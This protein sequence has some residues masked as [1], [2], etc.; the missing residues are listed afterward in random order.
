[1]VRQPLNMITRGFILAAEWLI[2]TSVAAAFDYSYEPSSFETYRIIGELTHRL[3]AS[4]L[5]TVAHEPTIAERIAVPLWLRLP[6]SDWA[7]KLD[8]AVA[9]RMESIR[10]E[11]NYSAWSK[12]PDDIVF[13]NDER[14]RRLGHTWQTTL[15]QVS[16]GLLADNLASDAEN[17][18]APRKIQGISS[19][20]DY[21]LASQDEWLS[22]SALWTDVDFS[23]GIGNR[24]WV[25]AL[26]D[27]ASGRN[28]PGRSIQEKWSAVLR[29]A[30]ADEKR[31][32][33]P[34]VQWTGRG[35]LGLTAV[36]YESLDV[37]LPLSI[38]PRPG[39]IGEGDK[40]LR[41][42]GLFL[43]AYFEGAAS[44]Q[45]VV[46]GGLMQPASTMLTVGLKTGVNF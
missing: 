23:S 28:D 46:V 11:M 2:L 43:G 26:S 25:P 22:E 27:N 9:Q 16:K 1:M 6:P 30:S 38:Y 39:I 3:N 7:A 20:V 15:N 21:S 31:L 45:S 41:D 32:A 8:E 33:L 42:E 44:S 37:Y 40:E 10:A 29:V 12:R 19:A 36:S 34:K 35:R 17:D 4:P 14:L 5:A 18:W 24:L 13:D